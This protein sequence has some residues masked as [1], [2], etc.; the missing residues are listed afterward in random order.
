LTASYQQV[1]SATHMAE[2]RIAEQRTFSACTE[3]P[4]NVST[5]A[6]SEKATNG[7]RMT[8]PL[9]FNDVTIGPF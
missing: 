6:A 8:I 4:L 1:G 2:S 3:R 7:K 9:G 5:R